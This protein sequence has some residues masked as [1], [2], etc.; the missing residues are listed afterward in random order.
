MGVGVC[1]NTSGIRCMRRSVCTGIGPGRSLAHG[2]AY[3]VMC[4]CVYVQV[5]YAF[6]AGLIVSI[7]LIPINRVISVYILQASKVSKSA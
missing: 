3:A 1:M 7:A 5:R 2:C 6:I 4:V